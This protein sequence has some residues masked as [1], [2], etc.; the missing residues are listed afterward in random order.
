MGDRDV[1]YL[2]HI[3]SVPNTYTRRWASVLSEFAEVHSSMLP[4]RAASH[5]TISILE[6]GIN[7]H[8]RFLLL[9]LSQL[10]HS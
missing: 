8:Y 2:Y 5:V 9:Q 3:A 1:L 6:Q 7:L 10:I 4:C